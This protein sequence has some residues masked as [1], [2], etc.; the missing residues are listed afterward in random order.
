MKPSAIQTEYLSRFSS[1]ALVAC[2]DREVGRTLA[3]TLAKSGILAVLTASASEACT[4]LGR[5]RFSLVFCEDCLTDGS[6]RDVLRAVKFSG[7]RVPVVVAC[8]VGD[9]DDYLEAVGLGAFDMVVGPFLAR[10][11]DWIVHRA[12]REGSASEEHGQNDSG[13]SLRNMSAAVLQK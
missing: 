13:A 5:E 3:D 4:W 10:D 7:R 11:V 8:R 6:Y 1:L 2:S 12:L 9:W